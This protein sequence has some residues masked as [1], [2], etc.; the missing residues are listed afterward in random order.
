LHGKADHERARETLT[1][2]MR[3]RWNAGIDGIT[4]SAGLH[5]VRSG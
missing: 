1:V 2:R 5:L 4:L 3:R